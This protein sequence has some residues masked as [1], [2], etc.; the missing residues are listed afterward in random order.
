LIDIFHWSD[1]K[2]AIYS[3]ISVCVCLFM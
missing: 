3:E 1:N 2:R